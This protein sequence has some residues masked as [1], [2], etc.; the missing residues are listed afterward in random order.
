[1]QKSLFF[2]FAAISS[3][4]ALGIGEGLWHGGGFR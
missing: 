3:G 4:A 2:G 1:M